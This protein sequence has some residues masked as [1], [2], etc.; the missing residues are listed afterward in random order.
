MLVDRRNK[1]PFQGCLS[2]REFYGFPKTS[3]CKLSGIHDNF[4][5]HFT[6][7]A[8]GKWEIFGKICAHLLLQ[9][10]RPLQYLI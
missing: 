3:L 10:A 4:Q 7:G 8:E 5:G 1:S 6:A 9:S 2:I